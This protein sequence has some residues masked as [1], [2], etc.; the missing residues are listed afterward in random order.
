MPTRTDTLP[1]HRR[2][3]FTRIDIAID[4]LPIW[5]IE[6][7]IPQRHTGDGFSLRRATCSLSGDASHRHRGRSDRRP[8]VGHQRSGAAS[9]LAAPDRCPIGSRRGGSMPA[10]PRGLC[11]H[12]RRRGRHDLRPAGD[13]VGFGRLSAI[14]PGSGHLDPYDTS[15]LHSGRGD[16]RADRCRQ[17]RRRFTHSI[18]GAPCFVIRLIPNPGQR[19]LICS[20]TGKSPDSDEHHGGERRRCLGGRRQPH[21]LFAR[22]G[23]TA[24]KQTIGWGPLSEIAGPDSYHLIGLTPEKTD[25]DGDAYNDIWL[26]LGG[27]PGTPLPI[28]PPPPPPVA[29]FASSAVPVTN[30]ALTA[31]AW[32]RT[33]GSSTSR[34]RAAKAD[35]AAER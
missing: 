29:T 10:T 35:A 7:S 27:P 3:A 6:G 32:P 8:G 2:A 19:S 30:A 17:C 21:G 11:R 28:V 23:G 14:R 12:R 4:G 16:F 1:P 25:R 13:R 33:A 34:T 31:P 18:P 15:A 26:A 5:G 24:W 22:T 9:D 20:T